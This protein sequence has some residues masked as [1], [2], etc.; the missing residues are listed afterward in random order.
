MSAIFLVKV[1]FFLK[2]KKAN[3]F[4][5]TSNEFSLRYFKLEICLESLKSA[6]LAKLLT[7]KL[8]KTQCILA[9]Y[10]GASPTSK[11]K[12]AIHREDVFL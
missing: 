8:K 3:I 6:S 12:L 9:V 7:G 2:K 1:S 4:K 5:I 11:L 10:S